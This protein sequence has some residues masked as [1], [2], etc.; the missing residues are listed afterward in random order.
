MVVLSM[1]NQYV[2]YTPI[3][4]AFLD[5]EYVLYLVSS[6][7]HVAHRWLHDMWRFFTPAFPTLMQYLIL[8]WF[9][10]EI[11]AITDA[12]E[13]LRGTLALDPEV[14][15]RVVQLLAAVRAIGRDSEQHINTVGIQRR[16]ALA[17][18]RGRRSLDLRTTAHG[19][20][21]DE[22]I[23]ALWRLADY[24]V[25]VFR[26]C[27]ASLLTCRPCFLDDRGSSGCCG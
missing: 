17:Q 8:D 14:A 3:I 26:G 11:R 9:R 20:P 5:I 21:G 1:N 25:C 10:A 23:E 2:I 27:R 12:L 22:G 18:P 24:G 15:V 13:T 6:S 16:M 19:G 7:G 4:P